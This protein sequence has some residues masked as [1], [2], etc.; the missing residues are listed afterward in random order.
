LQVE[1]HAA[2]GPY[3]QLDAEAPPRKP[4][5]VK[6]IVVVGISVLVI[7]GGLATVVALVASAGPADNTYIATEIES[8]FEL[9]RTRLQ[10][11][12]VANANS[13]A[14]GGP[15]QAPSLKG[16]AAVVVKVD[17]LVDS[18]ELQYP[19]QFGRKGSDVYAIHITGPNSARVTC[20]VNVEIATMEI[21][22][23]AGGVSTTRMAGS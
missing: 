14:S 20:H 15:A 9:I 4:A 11:Y 16:Q 10:A 5:N 1:N 2:E 19:R 21:T 3:A 18:R 7:L 17:A 13:L 8:D 12:Y 23:I 22:D 6:A